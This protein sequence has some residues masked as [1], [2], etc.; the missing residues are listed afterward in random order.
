[1]HRVGHAAI[2]TYDTLAEECVGGWEAFHGSDRLR[3]SRWIGAAGDGAEQMRGRGVNTG[4][5]YCGSNPT[6]VRHE[7]CGKGP[8][9][10]G[11]VPVEGRG[12]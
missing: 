1:M 10:I 12:D 3:A 7:A 11:K 9:V 6:V 4:M 5:G 8:R 2:G